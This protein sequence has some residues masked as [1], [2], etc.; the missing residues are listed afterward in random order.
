MIEITK[1]KQIEKFVSDAKKSDIVCLDTEFIREKT[2]LPELCLIQAQT[3][4][5]SYII[6]P[7]CFDDLSILRDLLL[8]ENVV[9]VFHACGQDIEVLRNECGILPVNIYDVQVASTIINGL[10][11]PS[12]GN[13]LSASIDVKIEKSESFTDWSRRPLT[14]KQ[15]KYAIED[16]LYLPELY[17]FQ[18][19]KLKSLGREDWLEEDFNDLVDEHK[20]S[21]NPDEQYLHLKRVNQLNPYELKLARDVCAWREDRAEIINLPRRSVISDEQVLE[22]CKRNPRSLDDLLAIRGIDC[23]LNISELR[24]VLGVLNSARKKDDIVLKQ[25]YKSSERNGNVDALV[26]AM[27]AILKIRGKENGISPSA[28]AN[29]SDLSLVARGLCDEARVMSG[30]RG[31]LVGK[32]LVALL[33]GQLTLKVIDDNLEI[34]YI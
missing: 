29:N 17:D 9:K 6:D 32:D 2:Y 18:I 26:D 4:D 16:V 3:R 31:K 11:H 12:L 13:L 10:Y 20:Y 27:N 7:F 22:I 23:A 33:N 34:V 28:I 21:T 24:E 30:W 8:D 5:E 1:I 14:P 25:D 15:V 19:S